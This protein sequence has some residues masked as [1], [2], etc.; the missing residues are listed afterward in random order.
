VNRLASFDKKISEI[1]V[2]LQRLNEP[3]FSEEVKKAV[4]K[5]DKKNL[6]SICKKAKIPGQYIG[7]IVSVIMSVSPE[8]WP[9]ES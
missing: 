5:N 9:A 4:E 3:E 6:I 2:S 7:T 1:S 8:K